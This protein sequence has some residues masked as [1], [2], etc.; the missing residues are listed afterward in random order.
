MWVWICHF[1]PGIVL[2][3]PDC[4]YES[5]DAVDEL[6]RAMGVFIVVGS[7]Y[8]SGRMDVTRSCR[9]GISR[10]ATAHKLVPAPTI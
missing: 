6:S 7:N 1:P 2:E 10:P 3:S 4:G 8:G 9:H 5:R